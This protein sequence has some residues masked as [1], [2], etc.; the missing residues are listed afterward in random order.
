M[1]QPFTVNGVWSIRRLQNLIGWP[2]WYINIYQL[3]VN[4]DIST[5]KI[6]L[7]KMFF[8]KCFFFL[9]KSFAGK[10]I[11]FI[12]LSMSK[13]FMEKRIQKKIHKE[14]SQGEQK[15]QNQLMNINVSSKKIHKWFSPEKKKL[16]FSNKRFLLAAK[17]LPY[18]SQH[19]VVVISSRSSQFFLQSQHR[20]WGR[21]V[22]ESRTVWS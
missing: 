9:W 2:S 18:F 22:H 1:D 13:L 4:I 12:F 6:L 16:N 11:E 15:C 8:A 5:N 19:I 21:P 20:M 10:H 3:I 17:K 14:F 7:V